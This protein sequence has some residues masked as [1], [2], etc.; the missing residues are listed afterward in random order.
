MNTRPEILVIAGSDSAGLAG[1]QR[2]NQ[3]I[4]AMGC[5]AINVISAN[6]AQNSKGLLASYPSD[7][8]IFKHQLAINSQR[9]IRVIK[10]GL[11]PSSQHIDILT[12]FLADIQNKNIPVVLDPVLSA[13]SGERFSENMEGSSLISSMQHLLRF[14]TVFTPNISEAERLSGITIHD[15]DAIVDASKAFLELGAQSVLIKG[16][17]HDTHKGRDFFN[18]STQTFWLDS[19]RQDTP[20]LRG[21]GCALASCIASALAKQ[22]SIEDAIVIGKMAINQGIRQNYRLESQAGPVN[23]THFPSSQIDLPTLSKKFNNTMEVAFPKPSLPDGTPAALGLY[24][25]V[26]T[27]AWIERLAPL[28]ISTIQ[29][30]S[31]NLSGESLENEIVKAISIANKFNCRLFINDYWELAIKHKAYG[32]HLGQEDLDDAD[33]GAIRDSGLRLGISTHCHYEV[34]RAHNFQPSYIA[35]GPI[36]HTNTKQMPWIPQGAQGLSY[37]KEVLTYPVVAI[38]GI[39]QERLAEILEQKPDGIAMITAITHS[40]NAEETALEFHN[41]ICDQT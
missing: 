14:C 29:L 16:G 2:D 13:S 27:A 17:H 24:P 37:W 1:I 35:C 36:Y 22:F 12:S 28:G 15:D 34:A 32:V 19:V 8:E 18:S 4:L 9:E 11:L 40:T 10:I 23:I 26:D 39:N 33:I 31:K 20:N 7:I 3:S 21:T 38:G 41:M 30:R 5:H 25:V 6:T